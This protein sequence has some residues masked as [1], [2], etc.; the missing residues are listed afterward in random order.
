MQV[1]GVEVMAQR[2]GEGDD[3]KESQSDARPHRDARTA[4][5]DEE[6]GEG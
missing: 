6:D 5:R 2:E 1:Q 4:H 3:D